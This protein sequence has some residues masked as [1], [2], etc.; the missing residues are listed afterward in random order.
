MDSGGD[1]ACSSE[2]AGAF[3]G[4]D[5]A[6]SIA[7]V[8]TTAD[9]SEADAKGCGMSL[10]FC[11]AFSQCFW[12]SAGDCTS[13]PLEFVSGTPT[14]SSSAANSI[15]QAYADTASC[16]NTTAT[17]LS[18]LTS[19]R[20]HRSMT[21]ESTFLR[22]TCKR[23]LSVVRWRALYFVKSAAGKFTGCECRF[24]RFLPGN[25]LGTF[26]CPNGLVTC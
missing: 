12:Q 13:R 23:I 6:W 18:R 16:A 9:A 1:V 8:T 5:R 7:S 2:E 15:G 4:S 20:V 19:F 3:A 24:S 21:R 11:C 26:Y 14:V 10:T 22:E 17:M 25:S